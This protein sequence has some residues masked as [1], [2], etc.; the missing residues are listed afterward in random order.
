MSAIP[1]EQARA[2]KHVTTAR[3]FEYTLYALVSCRLQITR[4]HMR[5]RRPHLLGVLMKRVWLHRH[6]A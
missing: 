4:L 5:R 3:R 2:A 6:V 1:E